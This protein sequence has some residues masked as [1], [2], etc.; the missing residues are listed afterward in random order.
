[1]VCM[2]MLMV[3]IA[4]SELLVR[5]GLAETPSGSDQVRIR[6]VGRRRICSFSYPC[7]VLERDGG[8]VSGVGGPLR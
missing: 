4:D 7:R 2:P 6:Q 5:R 1:M 8:A 3:K